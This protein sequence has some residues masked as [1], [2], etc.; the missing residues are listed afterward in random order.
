MR[1]AF[2]PRSHGQVALELLA[3]ATPSREL[4][5]MRNVF[6]T[7]DADGSGTIS[8]E[9]FKKAMASHPEFNSKEVT[10]LF[11]EVGSS[12]TPAHLFT[13]P[14]IHRA[15]PPLPRRDTSVMPALLLP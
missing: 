2:A 6:Y 13:D 9:E 11:D 15:P 12:Q 8:R 14:G 4:K 5:E 7:I 10:R 1:R 3:F